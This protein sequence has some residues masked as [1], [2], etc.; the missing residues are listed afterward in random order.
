[1][2]ADAEMSLPGDDLTGVYD[3]L[4]FI[5]ALKAGAPPEVGDRVVVV[6]GGNTAIDVAR[7]ARRLGAHV[8]TLA[9][10]RTPLEMPAYAHEVVEARDEGVQFE[11]LSEPVRFVGHDRLEGVVCQLMQLGAPDASGRRRPEPIEGTEFTIPADTVIRAV[12]QR[13]QPEIGAMVD[14]V[15]LERGRIVVD[16]HGRSTNPKVFAGGDAVNGGK[17]RGAGGRRRQARGA[18]DRRVVAMRELTEIRWHG[19]AG[20]G[21]KTAAQ[22]LA[23][24]LLRSGKSVQAFPEYRPERRGAPV[25]AYTRVSQN[26]RI[27]RHDSVTEPDLVAVLEPSLARDPEIASGLR[28]GGTLVVNGTPPA[29]APRRR[30][31][32]RRAG[33]RAR[34]RVRLRL[35]QRR[36][37][38]RGRGRARP[39]RARA[40]AGRGRR[41]ARTQDRP[42]RRARR[43]RGGLPMGELKPWQ[44]L[45]QGAIVVRDAAQ[46][47]RTGGWR[48][49]VRPELELS[50]CVDCLLCWLY[51]PDA[52]ILVAEGAVHGI[53][54]DLCKGCEICA[55][56]CPVGAITMVPE[57]VDAD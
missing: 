12:G 51:C 13:P 42:G 54:L 49:G 48:T 1:M 36:H 23:L 35:R 40:A 32:R 29:D 8:V 9:Y 39:A 55:E 19:R 24:A 3:S 22:V 46:Q 26:G 4:P 53:D 56:R 20:Q 25:R 38:R 16:E 41:G 11:W 44:E 17:E 7:E 2:G 57:A 47:Q 33:C 15:E 28:A 21:A 30:P 5:E 10:R 50:R 18:R 6:G 34:V 37:A 52:A 14:G 27:R 31:R 43:G 45:E